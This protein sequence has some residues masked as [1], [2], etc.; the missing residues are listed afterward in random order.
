[1]VVL[2]AVGRVAFLAVVFLAVAFLPV[3]FLAVLFFAGLV[4]L[5][6][7]FRV[8]VFLAPVLDAL[9]LAVDFFAVLLAVDLAARVFF[10]TVFFADA[11]LRVAVDFLAVLFFAGLVFLA[12][13][14]RV[15]VFLAAVL[16]AGAFLAVLFL[17]AAV[18]VAATACLPC[19]D[20]RHI[21]RRLFSSMTDATPITVDLILA[22]SARRVNPSIPSIRVSGRG[23]VRY[24]PET[25]SSSRRREPRQPR[26]ESAAAADIDSRC[27]ARSRVTRFW[28]TIV[29]HQ[30]L[31]GELTHSPVLLAQ[32]E[33][34]SAGSTGVIDPFQH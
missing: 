22:S 8:V 33:Y 11:T 4:F 32:R 25:R 23:V 21:A 31:M 16:L 12:A 6:A 30:R 28:Y 17:A 7:A 19:W 15:V 1:M 2:R 34:S 26:I 29:D 5:A 27:S 18:F 9:T 3:D 13:A 24:G 10:A 20:V 14:F